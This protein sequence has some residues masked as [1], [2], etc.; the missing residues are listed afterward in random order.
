MEIL[1]L[2]LLHDEDALIFGA[3]NVKLSRLH[4]QGI[5]IANGFVATALN[6]HLKTILE[7][8]DFGHKEIYEQSLILVKKE[9]DRIPIPD[10]LEKEL[11]DKKQVIFNDQILT[12]S[13]KVWL[14]MIDAWV[15][16][17]KQ[18]LFA[19][20]FFPGITDNLEPQVVIFINNIKAFGQAYLDNKEV[21]VKVKNGKIDPA[22][23]KK[24]DEVVQLANKKLIIPYNFEWILDGEIK[25]TKI[26]PY[27]P[28]FV[29][30]SETKGIIPGLYSSPSVQNDIFQ[31]DDRI[32]STVK[33][34]LDFSNGFVVEKNVDGIF[35]A[36]EKIFDLNKP[37]DSFEELAFRLVES[38]STFSNSPVFFK[39]ADKSE[40]MGKVRGTLRLI[41]QKSLLDPL[42]DALL[43]SKNNKNQ[44][45][46][47]PVIPFVRSVSELMEI[48]K[49]LAVK[50][51]TRRDNFQFW[52]ELAVPENILNLEQYLITGLD[53]VVINLDEMIAHLGGFDPKEQELAHY[54]KEVIAL[55]K[56][57]EEGIK[58]LHRSKLPF[59]ATGNL[60]LDPEVL[61]F[62]VEKGV[63]GIVVERYEALSAKD[64][65]HQTE[66][67]VILRKQL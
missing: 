10:I 16:Q 36:S 11:K 15:T 50:K 64:I 47:H 22:N 53:G 1:P 9:L 54:K 2:K 49:K 8:Y 66:K 56:F 41:H 24:L 29:T 5:P 65:L 55:I 34:F 51:I 62:L 39:L 6:L 37:H 31:K 40:G 3:L 23:L 57:L 46:V 30:L 32:K 12:S 48:K 19:N 63:Y 45:N 20:G 33:V 61:D 35:I 28:T 43:F 58:L 4:H 14:E 7:H 27:T 67:K 18:R 42:I 38:A 60:A 52:L 59:I 17:I 26:L 44:Q 13:K 21:I 25:I